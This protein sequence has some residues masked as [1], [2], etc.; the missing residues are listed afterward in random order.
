MFNKLIESLIN[1]SEKQCL[2]I[3][4]VN[5]AVFTVTLSYGNSN[6][7]KFSEVGAVFFATFCIALAIW[8]FYFL[9]RTTWY[10]WIISI[11]WFIILLISE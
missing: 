6:V 5:L 2:L 8:N 1:L 10:G 9:I 3:L 7:G 11:T 4:F